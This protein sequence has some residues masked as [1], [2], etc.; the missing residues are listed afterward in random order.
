MKQKFTETIKSSVTQKSIL[1]TIKL[2]G[3][4]HMKTCFGVVMD[5]SLRQDFTLSYGN[6]LYFLI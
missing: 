4:L 5:F 1:A 3:V 6:Y 2:T